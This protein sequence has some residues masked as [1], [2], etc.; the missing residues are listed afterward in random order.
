VS[1][2]AGVKGVERPDI[3]RPTTSTRDLTDVT[4]RLTEWLRARVSS[5]AEIRSVRLPSSTGMS[6]ETLLFDV[7]ATVGGET[8]VEP[9]VARLAPQAS[10]VPTFPVYDL[11][12][13]VRT[14]RLVR[15]RTS[16]PVPKV[17]WFEP[18][19]RYLGSPFLVMEQH[20]GRVPADVMPYVMTGWLFDASDAQRQHLQD[21]SI[22][23]LA[24][25]HALKAAP[26]EVAFLDVE[27]PGETPLRRHFESQRTYYE[28]VA[29]DGLRSP[30]LERTFGWLEQRWP[31]ESGTVV[32]WGDARI[33]NI[34]YEGF[35]PVAVLDWEMA[36]LAP[37][38]FDLGWM[39]ALHGFFQNISHRF[40][41][42]S[43]LPDLFR[44]DKAISTYEAA[45]GHT[46]R[47]LPWYETYAAL[48]H[49]IV[50]FRVARRQALL[51]GTPM[52]NDPDDAVIHRTMIE[53]M[54]DGSY[55]N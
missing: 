20:A 13:Q 26:E 11:A 30:L 48:R 18:D 25:L 10:A 31:R 14:M 5:G 39:I 44:R 49:G 55:F 40:G 51:D 15:E 35:D 23:V 37:R 52:P 45:T 6:S 46:I 24:D 12:S 34:L 36:A 3:D 32:C 19:E 54:L 7:I 1:S 27:F 38:E 43:G 53:S 16:V 42:G 50:L 28:W 21:A 29:S 47:D 22:R 8:R 4:A 17:R 33:G 2:A 41:L 9:F